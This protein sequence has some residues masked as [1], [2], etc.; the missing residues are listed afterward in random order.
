MSKIRPVEV[1][2]YGRPYWAS[3]APELFE[4][5]KTMWIWVCDDVDPELECMLE[6]D[7]IGGC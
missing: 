3:L 6:N 4:E 1:P 2:V 5:N 7:S